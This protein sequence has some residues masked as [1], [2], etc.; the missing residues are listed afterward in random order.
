MT[1]KRDGIDS[2][3]EFSSGNSDG[4][5]LFTNDSVSLHPTMA[6]AVRDLPTLIPGILT[7]LFGTDSYCTI[8]RFRKPPGARVPPGWASKENVSHLTAAWVD[9]DCYKAPGGGLSPVEVLNDINR[10]VSIGWIPL[11]S[12]RVESG[13]G[14]WLFWRIHTVELGSSLAADTLVKINRRAAEL[15][16]RLGADKSAT[17]IARWTRL[18]GAI[19]SKSGTPVVWHFTARGADAA[20]V[21]YT[22]AELAELFGVVECPV[23]AV[24]TDLRSPDERITRRAADSR[25]K[26]PARVKG[27]VKGAPARARNIAAALDHLGTIRG[28][29]RQGSRNL[30]CHYM[31]VYHYRAGRTLS[32]IY[33]L[34][35]APGMFSPPLSDKEIRGHVDG[36][37]RVKNVRT[38][39]GGW[40]P[41]GVQHMANMLLVTPDE[42]RAIM[43]GVGVSLPWFHQDRETPPDLSLSAVERRAARR[44]R[45]RQ[46]AADNP[47]ISERALLEILT[48]EGMQVSTH[49]VHTDLTA[50]G[51][52]RPRRSRRTRPQPPDALPFE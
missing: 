25:E 26:N 11:P 35:S 24:Y 28:G 32:E 5:I 9:L 51:L 16:E 42:S 19:N 36:A 29:Y 50:L 31:A 3:M 27:G 45:V 49:T 46:I 7:D 39:A 17:N 33:S 22:L 4:H 48:S 23:P 18:P 40:A 12:V 21:V 47:G 13:R 2:L 34:L 44:E 20:P 8:S 1:R 52:N 30:A 37:P 15:L 6:V 14:V 41:I 43:A 10:L 38:A